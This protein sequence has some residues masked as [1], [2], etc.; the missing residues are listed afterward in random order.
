MMLC[1][2][3]KMQIDDTHGE[4]KSRTTK[5]DFIVAEHMENMKQDLTQQKV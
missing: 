2:N 4:M 5:C 1:T 3:T